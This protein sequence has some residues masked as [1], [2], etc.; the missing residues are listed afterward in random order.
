MELSIALPTSGSWATP[1]N[2]AEIAELAEK[3][4]CR[5]VWTFQR[6]LDPDGSG[7]PSVY[8]S[9]LDPIVSLGFAAA[10]TQTVRLGLAV[11]NGPFFAPAVLAKQ[12]ASLDV[13]S[14]GRLDAGIG[15]GWHP[16]EFTAAGVPMER[17]GKRFDEWLD[18][19]DA[20]LTS[21]HVSFAGRFYTV[22]PSHVEPRPVQRPRP[23][24]LIGGSS[25]A[26]Y[27]RA[28]VRGDGWVAS[29]RAS[30]DDIAHAIRTI[31]DEAERAGKDR[32]SMHC[33][34]RGVTRVRPDQVDGADRAILQGTFSQ[35]ASDLAR[36]EAAGVDEVFFDLN[37]DSDEV[38]NPDADPEASMD[39]A[40]AVLDT[41]IA[42]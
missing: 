38:G 25:E 36:F 28:A 8:R 41:C 11:V 17:R 22:P 6:V 24:I 7:L 33:V 31:R 5:G 19:L 39:K 12:L 40:R 1:Q 35:I 10:V 29:S 21:D 4:G 2:I 15:L 23:P 18:C 42:R 37:F 16:D 14:S 34:V 27:R 26:A 13:L 32:A 3:R 9:V 20:V 30:V